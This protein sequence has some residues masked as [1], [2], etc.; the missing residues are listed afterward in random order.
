VTPPSPPRIP[1]DQPREGDR[2]PELF[3]AAEPARA[4]CRPRIEVLESTP[5][6]SPRAI[7]AFRLPRLRAAATKRRA[8]AV[9]LMAGCLLLGGL[10]GAALADHS[11]PLRT[12]RRIASVA[13]AQV[14][15]ARQQAASAERT[16]TA[17]QQQL[18]S[19]QTRQHVLQTQAHILRQ[20]LA[21]RRGRRRRRRK[22]IA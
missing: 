9:T 10:L 20:Q 11:G 5:I 8:L 2:G 3:P 15:V 14:T 13:E 19:A 4:S 1:R 22:G 18:A 17:V 21:A 12:E 7:V 6:S 16:L